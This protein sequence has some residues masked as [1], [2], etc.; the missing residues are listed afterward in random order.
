M[1]TRRRVYV[2]NRQNTK[3]FQ[4]MLVS[5]WLIQGPI[6][7]A[8]LSY[9]MKDNRQGNNE[10]SSNPRKSRRKKH[11]DVVSLLCQVF[12]IETSQ[13]EFI[14]MF[15]NKILVFP[16][17]KTIRYVF[18]S[19]IFEKGNALFQILVLTSIFRDK[20]KSDN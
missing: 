13:Q 4:L 15:K 18:I 9:S 1:E 17:K 14:F 3:A 7:L 20:I 8:C 16:K 2:L 10:L 11:S 19:T 12:L 5:H 6:K